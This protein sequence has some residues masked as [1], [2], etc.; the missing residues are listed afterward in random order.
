L[1]ASAWTIVGNTS[2]G[3]GQTFGQAGG[4]GQAHLLGQQRGGA[5][6][7]QSVGSAVF[8]DVNLMPCS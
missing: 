1:I 4:L 8:L 3:G 5:W 6:R 7:I 2:L